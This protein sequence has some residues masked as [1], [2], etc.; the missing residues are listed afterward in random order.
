MKKQLLALQELIEVMDPELYR[1]LGSFMVRTTD[2]TKLTP[3]TEKTDGL[4]LFFCFRWASVYLLAH[5]PLLTLNPVGFS[6]RSNG[7]LR[8]TMSC[9]CGKYCGRI[10]TATTLFYSLPWL[11]SNPIGMLFSAI[12]SRYVHQFSSGPPTNNKTV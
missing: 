8:L 6:L 4:N 9:V 11:C 2:V 7:S 5:T 3:R 12:W 10:I 1:H